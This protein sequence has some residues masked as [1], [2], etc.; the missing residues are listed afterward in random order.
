VFG[1]ILA[2]QA[3]WGLGW[4]FI[5][6]A[7]SAWITDEVGAENV[8]PVFLRSGQ[9]GRVGSLIGIPIS[10]VLGSLFDV[11]IPVIVGGVLML[12][13]GVFL[14]LFM[15]ENGFT[16]T[17][18]SERQTFQAM[19][20]TL[21][22]G[23]SL[24]RGRPTLVAFLVIG[25]FVGLYSEGYDRLWTPHLLEN[26]SFPDILGFDAVIWFGVIRISVSILGIVVNEIVNRRLNFEDADASV[27]ALQGVYAGMVL[28]LA[29]FALA[30]NFS[31]AFVTLIAFNV[32]RGVTFPIQQAWINKFIESKVRATVLSVSSQVDA[33]GQMTG[34]PILGGVGDL[35]GV[36][37]AIA[38]A[39]LL[40][41]PVVPLFQRTLTSK[42][43]T[44]ETDDETV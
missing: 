31:M 25:L 42:K 6:G 32:L 44:V 27:R 30:G 40:L 24:V 11:N 34:G 5:S 26:F 21:G 1:A 2:A 33:L 7:H 28:T 35:F 29:I 8:G 41:L 17:P 37:A 16:P 15:P 18:A 3:L 19:R 14:T 38:S 39:S 20:Q 12:L 36:R 4:T 9:W 43:K 13:L 10:V 23:V 22:E